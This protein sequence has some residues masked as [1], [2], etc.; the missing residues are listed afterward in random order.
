MEP[1]LGVCTITG[2]RPVVNKPMNTRAQLNQHRRTDD[3]DPPIAAGSH[4]TLMYK[5]GDTGEEH[6]SSITEFL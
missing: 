2:T 1:E 3:P 6:F 5:Q 4:Y